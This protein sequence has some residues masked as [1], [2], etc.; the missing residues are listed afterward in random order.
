MKNYELIYLISPNISDEEKTALAQGIAS[1]IKEQEGVLE[2]QKDM[3]KKKLGYPINKQT[4]AHIGVLNFSLP[5]QKI[6]NLKN[7]LKEK[8]GALRFMLVS[9]KTSRAKI[10]KRTA[11]K[12][13]SKT[14]VKDEKK[15]K[16]KVELKEVEK[17]LE[18][19]LN[20]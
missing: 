10:K 1:L 13:P 18:E 5:P 14:F 4:M 12:K 7:N 3:V 9:K 16:E 20:E 6:E 11:F 19:I 17:K 15:P 8:K 2:K